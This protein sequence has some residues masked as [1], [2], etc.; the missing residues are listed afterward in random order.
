MEVRVWSGDWGL[1]SVDPDCLSMLAYLKFCGAPVKV[2]HTDN[3]FRSPSGRLPVLSAEESGRR[4]VELDEFWPAVEHLRTSSS[5][6]PSWDADACLT[7]EQRSDAKAFAELVKVRLVPGLLQAFWVDARNQAEL[8]RPWFAR[9]L[10]FPLCFVYPNRYASEARNLV[11]GRAAGLGS[12]RRAGGQDDPDEAAVIET[13]VYVR[14][15]ECMALL[16]GRLGGSA[17]HPF[18]FGQEPSSLD[19]LVYGHLAPLL[20]APLPNPRLQT[21]LKRHDH[22]VAFI[23]RISARYFPEFASTY[24]PEDEAR[25]AAPGAPAGSQPGSSP[26]VKSGH[27][28]QALEKL[29]PAAAVLFAAAAMLGYARVSGVYDKILKPLKKTNKVLEEDGG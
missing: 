25:G 14:A 26:L 5:S 27:F 28:R 1:A 9:K 23:T 22:L 24:A 2:R 29:R 15:D 6:S 11:E 3:P 20:K 16:N 4:P 8:T 7:A 17:G 21:S 18:F 10:G 12:C 13:E 19:A